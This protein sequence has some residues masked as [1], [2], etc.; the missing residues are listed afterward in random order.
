MNNKKTLVC[1]FPKARTYLIANVLSDLGLTNLGWHIGFDKTM[2]SSHDDEKIVDFKMPLDDVKGITRA[3][4][5][6]CNMAFNM[7]PP[8]SF[9]VSHLPPHVISPNA[10]REFQFIFL[11][12]DPRNCMISTF[13]YMRDI[14]PEEP[15]YRRVADIKEVQT[16][17]EAYL[18]NEMEVSVRLWNDM[19]NWRLIKNALSINMDTLAGEEDGGRIT[20]AI[21]EFVG[22]KKVATDPA[23]ATKIYR[24]ATGRGSPT[25]NLNSPTQI[26][27]S[28]ACEDIFRRFG[29][30]YLADKLIHYAL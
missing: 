7:M 4:E 25:K 27:W 8:R 18:E 16:Q 13:K 19:L 10:L 9:A 22:L 12:R 24:G 1:S 23:R 20:S 3:V 17:F 5:I 26:T 6:N 28:D 15:S 14:L 2:I 29:G 11:F 21:A 30:G